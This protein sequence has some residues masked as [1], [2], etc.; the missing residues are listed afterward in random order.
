MNGTNIF[1]KLLSN[2]RYRDYKNYRE[3]LRN[4]TKKR[5][6]I[7]VKLENSGEGLEVNREISMLSKVRGK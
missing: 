7:I 5:E 4:T 3:N 2:Y 6:K 1:L